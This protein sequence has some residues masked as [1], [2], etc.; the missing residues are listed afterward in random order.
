[1][2]RIL[3]FGWILGRDL[4]SRPRPRF[5]SLRYA[6]AVRDPNRPHLMGIVNVTPDSFSD[7][8]NYFGQ[9]AAVEHALE[10]CE[11]G[12]TMIDVGGE[13]T[14]PGAAAVSA[15]EQCRRVVP[16]IKQLAD[17]CGNRVQLSVDTRDERVARQAVDVGATMINDVSASLGPVAAE[18]GVDYVAM[19]MR[20]TPTDMQTSPQYGDVV[21]EVQQFL[22]TAATEASRRST[23]TVYVDPGIGF[24]KTPQHNL[25]LIRN[26]D[27]FT[28]G[29]FPVV[30]GVS[31]KSFLGALMA[32]ATAGSYS[33]TTGI[34]GV[35]QR[36]VAAIV[37]A[38]FA[39][40]HGVDVLRVHDVAA[41]TAA[42]DAIFEP[43][44]SRITNHHGGF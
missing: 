11:A 21:A 19:H 17:T 16:V 15:D 6:L 41:H 20:G 7:G 37:V 44:G 31:R 42:L 35:H 25:D 2:A 36:D 23:N 27:V 26:L 28:S 5:D 39:A 33:G 1:M 3:R 4:L 12:A 8:G 32:A 9:T 38:T 29:T 22:V 43:S 30:L 40:V 34:V 13:S 10:L 24:G 14:R 18:L